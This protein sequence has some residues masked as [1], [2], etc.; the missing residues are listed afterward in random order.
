MS[1]ARF[2]PNYASPHTLT[3]VCHPETRIHKATA[4]KKRYNASVSLWLISAHCGTSAYS[5]SLPKIGRLVLPASCGNGALRIRFDFLH[6]R[7]DFV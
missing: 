4:T 3:G 2:H 1:V 6:Q 7:Y 5:G